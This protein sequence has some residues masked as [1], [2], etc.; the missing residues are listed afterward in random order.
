MALVVA[1]LFLPSL[2]IV[3][4]KLFVI[5][6]SRQRLLPLQ[7][8]SPQV[9]IAT[10]SSCWHLGFFFFSLQTTFVANHHCS[11]PLF[12]AVIFYFYFFISFYY[13]STLIWEWFLFCVHIMI[14]ILYWILKKLPWVSFSFLFWFF[15]IF[16]V[17]MLIF[18]Y[19]LLLLPTS[20]YT[21]I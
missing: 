17:F 4:A 10:T 15:V 5:A 7:V 20:F 2:V 9:A 18:R 13:L 8:S 3:V 19:F 6:K 16:V 12:L 21:Y 14:P 1:K 11:S